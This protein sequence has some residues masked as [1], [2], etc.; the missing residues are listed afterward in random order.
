MNNNKKLI[1]SSD[2]AGGKP[3]RDIERERLE[4]KRN[5]IIERTKRVYKKN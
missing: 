1:K 3:V 2:V 5:T 4:E